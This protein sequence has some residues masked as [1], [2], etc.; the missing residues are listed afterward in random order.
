MW[1]PYAIAAVAF[2]V[3]VVAALHV[4]TRKRDVRAAIGWVGLIFLVP[5]VGALLY[6]MFGLNRIQRRASQLHRARRRLL[7]STPQAISIARTGTASG[8]HPELESVARLGE[9]LSGRPLL[10]GNR[11]EPLYNGDQAYPAMIAAIDGA[12]RTIALSSYIFA[13]DAAG[14][15]FVNAL[16]AATKRG[17]EVRVLVDGF[18]VRYTWP[19]VHKALRVAGVPVQLFLPR[20]HQAG[21]AFFNLRNHRKILTVD[22]AVGFTGGM[23]IQARNVHAS[24]PPRPVR[25]VHF[26]IEGPLVGQMQEA[27]A[28]DWQFATKEVLDGPGWFPTLHDVGT[29]T[30]R[31][32]A[33][34]PDGNLEILRMVILGALTSAR[35]SVRIVTPYFLPDPAMV[36]ALAVTAL[37]GVK[38]EI[39]LPAR[40]NI[41]VVQWAAMAQLWQVLRPGCHV[42]LSPLPFDHAKLMVIDRR[43]SLFGSTNWDPRSLRLNFELD[44]ES[45]CS[46]CAARIDDQISERIMESRRLTLAEADGRSFP[47]KVRDGVARLFSPYL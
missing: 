24:N 28:E 3:S 38:V 31:V 41:P 39:V 33:D 18:G 11:I 21:L 45:Y 22:G 17:V 25:D 30:A 20:V 2:V 6:A 13:D 34:G 1:W 10:T 26:R 23:N 5:G 47:I 42:Y 32:I 15:P 12:R 37:R 27:F 8:V 35:H 44:V 36:A 46:V 9:Q 29:T 16:A 19:P 40:V 7:L 14:R 4:V 43:W